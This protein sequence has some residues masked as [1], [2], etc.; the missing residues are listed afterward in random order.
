MKSIIRVIEAFE[1]NQKI[2]PAG[3]FALR[4]FLA[5]L[6]CLHWGYKVV[7]NG[8]GG[9]VAFFEKLGYPGFFAYGDVTFE[10]IIVISLI[11]G[12]YTRTI[13]ILSLAILIPAIEIWIPNGIWALHGGYEFMVLWCLLEVV[14]ALTGPGP[15]AMRTLNLGGKKARD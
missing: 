8:M 12:L 4:I 14:V 15:W 1:N 9:T 13:S 7:Y 3:I 11:L 5:L 2:V 6:W 10:V